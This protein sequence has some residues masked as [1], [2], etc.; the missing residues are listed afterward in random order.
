[1]AAELLR[2]CRPG[3][4]IGLTAW[5]PASVM[6]ATQA[7]AANYAPIPPGPK[8]R[9]PFEWGTEARVRELFGSAV[10]MLT[11]EPK[12]TDLCAASPAARVEF[13]RVYL[14]PTKALFDRLDPAAEQ[15]LSAELAGCFERFNRAADGTLVAR[16]DYLQVTAT[17]AAGQQRG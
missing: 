14:G 7:L 12:T 13:N 17:R 3:G 5:T 11:A 2:V 9:S 16:A 10:T 4:R 15:A 6:A 1:V 8:P